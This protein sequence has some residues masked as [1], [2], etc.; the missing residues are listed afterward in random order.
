MHEI[1]KQKD[2]VCLHK[3]AVESEIR[4]DFCF[5]VQHPHFFI[6]VSLVVLLLLILSIFFIYNIKLYFLLNIIYYYYI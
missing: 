4:S 3:C 2:L 1:M 6:V 5:C